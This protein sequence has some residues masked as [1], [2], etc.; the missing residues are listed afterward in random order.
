[1]LFF[2]AAPGSRVTSSKLNENDVGTYYYSTSATQPS[3]PEVQLKKDT[4]ADNR[5]E[6]VLLDQGSASLVKDTIEGTGNIGVDLFQY[7]GQTLASQSSANGIKVNDMSEAA[8][9]VESDKG[10]GDKPG[11]FSVINSTFSGDGRC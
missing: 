2:G 3:S 1:M 4:F 9:K 10:A 7:E 8:I 11:K 6:G 5:Y